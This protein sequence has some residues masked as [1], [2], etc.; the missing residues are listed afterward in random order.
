MHPCLRG[1]LRAL[2]KNI[3]YDPRR[4]ELYEL[5]EDALRFISYC[6]GRNSFNDILHLTGADKNKAQELVDY[7]VQEGLVVDMH[8]PDAR[9]RYKIIRQ[10]SPSLRYL[11]LHVTERCNLDCRHCYLGSKG[12]T[13]LPLPSAKKAV[14]EFS[15]RGLKLLITGGEPLLYPFLWD[16]LE[17]SRKYPIRIEV[18]SNGTYITPEVAAKLSLFVDCVQVS[19]DGLQKGHELLRGKGTYNKTVKGIENLIPYVDVSIATMIHS[20]NIDEFPALEAMVKNL[21]AKEW[22]LDVPSP[23]GTMLSNRELDPDHGAAADVYRNYGFGG[24]THE[25]HED[26]SCGAHLCSIT[27]GGDITKCGFFTK[28]VGNLREISI[29]EAWRRI[30]E[31]Y[32]PRLE[33]LE[34]VGCTFLK[35]CRGGCRYRAKEARDFHGRDPFMCLLYDSN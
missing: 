11:Q 26:Y 15:K 10:N 27:V 9:R 22:N 5:D 34:C 35:E 7:L 32:L 12:S 13:D 8:Y 18:L 31:R 29:A 2:E 28:G 30:T 6:T 24:E 20:G 23:K 14:K 19:L 16:L 4:D 1:V 33:E 17:Y 21:G 3:L 25:G